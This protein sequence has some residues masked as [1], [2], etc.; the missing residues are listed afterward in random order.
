MPPARGAPWRCPTTSCG[1]AD[2]HDL[3]GIGT[4][5]PVLQPI[6]DDS[7]RQG[8]HLGPRLALGLS[9]G[10]DAREIGHLGEPTAV[11]LS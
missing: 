2:K 1:G 11:F 10:E 4:G 3:A 5:F 9:V 6:G 7:E 8:L